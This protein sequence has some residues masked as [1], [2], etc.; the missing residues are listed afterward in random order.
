MTAPRQFDVERVICRLTDIEDSG[1]RGF[2][3]GAG[4]WPLRGLVVRVRD[5]VH[6]Y[7]NRCPHAGHPLNLRP[8]EFLTRDKSLLLCSSHG[9]LFEKENGYCVAGP[10]A[11]RSLQT[12]RLKI[13]AGFVMLADDVD[14]ATLVHFTR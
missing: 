12:V 4:D 9:A 7:I 8:N 1:T 6:G 2:T 13:N 3:L 5:S 10:C 14:L 11:G